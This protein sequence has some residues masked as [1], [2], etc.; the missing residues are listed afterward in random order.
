M[1][2]KDLLPFSFSQI[3]TTIFKKN[4]ND[5]VSGLKLR[6]AKA[7]S[8][9]YDHYSGALYGIIKQIIPNE[10][11]AND[12]LL[13]TFINIF[14]KIED[15]DSSKARFFTWMH[16]IARKVSIDAMRVKYYHSLSTEMHS[17][18]SEKDAF[19][20]IMP[21]NKKN[22][23]AQTNLENLIPDHRIIIEF[24]YNKG[25]S[26]EEFARSEAVSLEQVNRR[27]KKA[28]LELRKNWDTKNLAKTIHV[29]WDKR[30]LRPDD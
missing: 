8:Y 3:L 10:K 28:L 23:G 20:Q 24:I 29:P 16:H 21:E 5:L 26:Q 13:E 27:L 9:L 6:D 19:I 22:I 12:A 15:Y 17:D 30:K 1:L 7:Y 25:Y 11:D 2:C 14:D 4:D 18:A